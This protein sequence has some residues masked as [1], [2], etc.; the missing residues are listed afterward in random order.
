[1]GSSRLPGKVM[2]P[3]LGKP[4]LGHLLDRIECCTAANE[5]VVAT[6]VGIETTT[7]KFANEIARLIVPLAKVPEINQSMSD[8]AEYA[9][10]NKNIRIQSTSSNSKEK[11]KYTLGDSL[12]LV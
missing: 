4:L 9:L 6:S 10:Q 8:A 1:M 11:P 2:T 3:V 12:G 7:E 5:I